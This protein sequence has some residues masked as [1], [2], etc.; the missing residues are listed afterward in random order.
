MLGRTVIRMALVAGAL[1]L[2]AGPLR[3]SVGLGGQTQGPPGRVIAPPSRGVPPEMGEIVADL[4]AVQQQS[5]A[6]RL[7]AL[8]GG[9]DDAGG[10]DGD[11]GGRAAQPPRPFAD[12][13]SRRQIARLRRDVRR[14][15]R[16]A[17]TA[18]DRVSVAVWQGVY[19]SGGRA[20]AV[21][22]LQRSVRSRRGM[23]FRRLPLVRTRLELV[24]QERRWTVL[25]VADS[26]PY[27]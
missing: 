9:R 4:G 3:E 2:V 1:L 10:G 22:D 16:E 12:R 25:D 7:G 6:G 18:D 17:S 20:I 23:P 15:L 24:R 19:V 8:G 21:A 14:A 11:A 26:V 13:G 27:K 5:L